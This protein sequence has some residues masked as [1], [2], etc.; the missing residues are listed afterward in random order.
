M[1]VTTHYLLAADMLVK[2]YRQTRCCVA[3]LLEVL[4]TWLVWLLVQVQRHLVHDCCHHPCSF[5]NHC[6]DCDRQGLSGRRCEYPPSNV[7]ILLDVC[8]HE[9][10]SWHV[11]TLLKQTYCL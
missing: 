3:W 6:H 5:T 10:A 11:K 8:S 1:F 2:H 7:H 9:L 4:L